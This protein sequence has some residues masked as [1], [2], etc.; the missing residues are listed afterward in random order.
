MARILVVEDDALVREMLST[1]L[2][3]HG[4]EV[5][6]ADS[7]DKALAAMANHPMDLVVTDMFMP[8]MTGLEIINTLKERSKG[9][10]IIAISGGMR[11]FQG[12]DSLAMA[13]AMGADKTMSKPV[14][15]TQLIGA[16]TDLVG[17]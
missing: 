5:H 13:R 15:M 14:P 4:Y 17:N 8:G 12:S 9:T 11:H 1:M 2:I 3:E 7:G 10:K 6:I 16:V